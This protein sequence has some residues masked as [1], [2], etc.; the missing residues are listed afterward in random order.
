[1]FVA[2]I[3]IFGGRNKYELD[4]NVFLINSNSELMEPEDF[5]NYF[6]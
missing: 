2:F 4:K 3:I 1:M 5:Y 6:E